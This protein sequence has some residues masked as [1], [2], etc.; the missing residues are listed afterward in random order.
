MTTQQELARMTPA[1]RQELYRHRHIT[2]KGVHKIPTVRVRREDG[3]EVTIN[4]DD[5]NPTI[6]TLIDETTPANAAAPA[7][8]VIPNTPAEDQDDRR[9]ELEALSIAELKML[10]EWEGV[11][12]RSRLKTKEAIV[13]ALMAVL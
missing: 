2:L 3:H 13:D 11:E 5:Y 7:K 12:G 9:A 1:Q 4:K 6:H 8:P 10:P